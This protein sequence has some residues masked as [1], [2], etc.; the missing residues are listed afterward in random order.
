MWLCFRYCA[1]LVA[2]AL[3]YG[4]CLRF[5]GDCG[6][7]LLWGLSLASFYGFSFGRLCLRFCAATALLGVEGVIEARFISLYYLVRF[8]PL[9]FLSHFGF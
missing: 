7:S 6:L 4:L 2:V 8:S 3:F 1:F 9:S 5:M